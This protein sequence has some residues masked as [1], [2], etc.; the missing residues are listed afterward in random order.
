MNLNLFSIESNTLYS[1]VFSYLTLI[2]TY[3]HQHCCLSD[4]QRKLSEITHAAFIFVPRS[5]DQHTAVG[6]SPVK[7]SEQNEGEIIEG[8]LMKVPPTQETV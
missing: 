3:F 4:H 1:L 6:T 7:L 5:C 2:L 8:A